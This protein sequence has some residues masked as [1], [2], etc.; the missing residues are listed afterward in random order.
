MSLFLTKWFYIQIY[1]Y[2][3]HITANMYP[4]SKYKYCFAW[5]GTIFYLFAISKFIIS[6]S[7]FIFLFLFLNFTINYTMEH[8][9]YHFL[10]THQFHILFLFR[11]SRHFID[12]KKDIHT[13]THTV[14]LLLRKSK[15]LVNL[16]Q[17]KTW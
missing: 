8:F 9:L 11:M 15:I 2:I 4:F 16:F 10:Y 3:I 7:L 14:M 1:I 17:M 13:H 6:N 12:E 5:R